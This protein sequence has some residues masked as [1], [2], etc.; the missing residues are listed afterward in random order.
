MFPAVKVRLATEKPRP[1]P[2]LSEVEWAELERGT[3]LNLC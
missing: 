3:R 2:A 1:K